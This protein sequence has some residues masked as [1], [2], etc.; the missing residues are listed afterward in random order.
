MALIR[1]T[2]FGDAIRSAV[3]LDLGDL[4]R[5]G[6]RLQE[7][8]RAEAERIVAE[9]RAE[10]ERLLAGAAE[11]GR[12]EGLARGLIEGRE[13]GRAEGRAAALKEW[14]ERLATLERRW[15]EA[16]D[17]FQASRDDLLVRAGQDV[18]RLAGAIAEKITRRA[19][20]LDETAA[21][22]QLQGVLELLARPTRLAV[23]I[24]PDDRECV[25]EALAALTQRLASARHVEIV[26]DDTLE[27]GSCVARSGAGEIDASIGTQIERIA[28][29]LLPDRRPAGP[30]SGS[31]PE[32]SA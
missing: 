24:H 3:V 21:A 2:Q 13:K 9:A 23:S 6:E 31:G 7:A 18:L 4:A 11:R 20:A 19:V 27:R 26:L 12:A 28:E 14:G 30:A 16:L 32:R 15:G 17:A 25:E 22:A 10:R 5:Q 1:K 8:A 29:L